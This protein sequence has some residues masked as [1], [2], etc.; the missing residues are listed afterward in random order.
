MQGIEFFTFF[1]PYMKI[2]YKINDKIGI[3]PFEKYIRWV[4]KDVVK[5][6]QTNYSWKNFPGMK[7]TW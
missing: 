1:G 7:S 5:T 3:K 2:G 6:I 4:E